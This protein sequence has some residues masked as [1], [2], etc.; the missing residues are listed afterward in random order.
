VLSNYWI[1]G[2]GLGAVVVLVLT[3]VIVRQRR[4]KKGARGAIH[5]IALRTMHD[6]ILPDD[7]DNF[8]YID[9]LVMTGKGLVVLDVK[10]YAGT[11]F[12]G[13]RLDEWKVIGPEGTFKFPNPLGLL[14]QRVEAVRRTIRGISVEGYVL[15]GN[16]AKISRAL[17]WGVITASELVE[18]YPRPNA[19]EVDRIANAFAPHWAQIERAAEPADS[20]P[21]S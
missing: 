7:M 8:I 17:P 12:A 13:D 14:Q 11:I 16:Q 10:E 2:S 9:Y 6:F 15:F 5:T 20:I 21:P 1:V 19:S 3:L 18:R 4:R